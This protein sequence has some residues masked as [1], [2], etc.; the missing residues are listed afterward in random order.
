[1]TD[2]DAA[3]LIQRLRKGAVRVYLA[4]EEGPA[5]DLADMLTKAAD[6]LTARETARLSGDTLEARAMEVAVGCGDSRFA[7]P[8]AMFA[9][10]EIAR[11]VMPDPPDDAAALIQ[12]AE[13]LLKD[14]DVRGCPCEQCV[15]FREILALL[16]AREPALSLSIQKDPLAISALLDDSQRERE[17]YHQLVADIRHAHS[18]WRDVQLLDLPKAI[19]AKVTALE[20]A[21]TT[22]QQE[23]DEQARMLSE[24]RA[25][26]T[27]E[28]ETLMDEK[29]ALRDQVATLTAEREQWAKHTQEEYAKLVALRDQVAQLQQV[30]VMGDGPVSNTPSPSTDRRGVAAARGEDPDPSPDHLQKESAKAVQQP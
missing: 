21:L 14:R 7:L 3:A 27:T 12:R 28:I 19:A 29:D 10:Q 17:M 4:A 13:Q 22:A 5:A 2:P 9:E 15:V 25:T 16:T 11:A 30:R 18:D 6:A 1:M 8:L 26:L 20:A 23:R 24:S